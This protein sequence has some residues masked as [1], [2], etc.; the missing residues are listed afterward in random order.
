MTTELSTPAGA[1]RKTTRSSR[2]TYDI[3]DTLIARR[4]VYPH[5]IFA[6]V[7]ARSGVEGFAKARVEAE[8][9]VDSGPYALEDIYRQLGADHSLDDAA[10]QQLMQMEVQ[11]ELENV[12]PIAEHLAE[13]PQD[14]LLVTDMYLP[15]DVIREM[16]KI[17]GLTRDVP[18]L[19]HSHG[20]SSGHVW[21]E[22]ARLGVQCVHL[23][24]NEQSDVN[25]AR[26]A[27]MRARLTTISRTTNFEQALNALGARAVSQSIR[28]ARLRVMR[29]GLPDWLYRLQTD[30]NLPFLM[31][32]AIDLIDKAHAAGV[33]EVL[34]ASRDGR[35]LQTAF[36]SLRDHIDGVGAIGSRYWYTSRCAR[37]GKSASYLDYCRGLFGER[38][39]IADLCGTGASTTTLLR[40]MGIAKP[41]HVYVGEK[42][43]SRSYADQMAAQYELGSS[44][45]IV[46][47]LHTFS[48]DGFVNNACMEELNYVP[49]GMVRDV[50]ML[51]YGALPIRDDIDFDGD[52]LALIEKQ[53]AFVTQFFQALRQELSAEDLQEFL[54]V[55]PQV[56]AWL[57]KQGPKLAA[58]LSLLRAHIGVDDFS[59]EVIT[60]QELGGK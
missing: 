24:D 10:V 2:K 56:F 27:G 45:R 30:L 22:L 41:P 33:D 60:M 57:H 17:A 50:E 53:Y 7:E 29:N 31:I 3:F 16:L 9:A 42:V 58:E 6:I 44:D 1:A 49:E 28:A 21:R 55:L 35:N 32:C 8:R 39:L 4:C 13:L 11:A 36:D 12:I 25:K 37:T 20:K 26:D 15:V 38:S 43:A 51:S 5:Q 18:I 48:T 23:G 47:A 34:F 14:A 19:I 54:A 52:A 59:N 46:D 40:D